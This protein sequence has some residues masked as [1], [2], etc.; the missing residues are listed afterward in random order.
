MIGLFAVCE[1]GSNYLIVNHTRNTKGYIPLSDSVLKPEQFQIGQLLVAMVNSEIGGAQTGQ[2]Y[3]LSSGRAG[4]NRKL[5]LTLD[6]KLIN[7]T[8]NVDHLT[9]NMVL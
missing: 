3:N 9:K 1:I 6:Q 4:L 8:Q 7:K 5:Q 2:I